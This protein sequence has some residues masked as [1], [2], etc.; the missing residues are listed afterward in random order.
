MFDPAARKL[1]PL[2]SLVREPEIPVKNV[3][4]SPTEE[5]T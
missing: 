4:A 1:A 3:A 5:E 2:G